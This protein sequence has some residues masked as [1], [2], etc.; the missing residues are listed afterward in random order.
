[1][2]READQQVTAIGSIRKRRCSLVQRV[3]S[4]WRLVGGP[5]AVDVPGRRRSD[6]NAFALPGGY[7]YVTRPARPLGSEAELA[8]CSARDGHVT[9]GTR[10][11]R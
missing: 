1:M 7:I 10:S 2:G 6:V 11:A 4:G 8:R 5:P 9:A 3:G